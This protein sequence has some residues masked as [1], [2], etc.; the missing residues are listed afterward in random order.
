MFGNSL[1]NLA[2]SISYKTQSE[3][4]KSSKMSRDLSLLST[5][6][7]RETWLKT[8]VVERRTVHANVVWRERQMIATED[9]IYFARPDSDV[10]VDKL[11][12]QD[13]VS[14]GKVDNVDKGPGGRFSTDGLGIA[15]VLPVKSS[16][17]Q[18]KTSILPHKRASIISSFA[19]LESIQ[20]SMRETF[21][22]EIKGLFGKTTRSYFVRVGSFDE[23]EAWILA[24]ESLLKSSLRAQARRGNWLAMRQ[25]DVDEWYRSAPIRFGIAIAILIDFLAAALEAEYSPSRLGS[26]APASALV[27]L[28]ALLCALFALELTVCLIG[29]WRNRLGTPFISS[30]S[31]WALAAAVV[32]HL[33]GLLAPGLGLGPLRVVRVLRLFDVAAGFPGFRACQM[34]LNALRR[35]ELNSHMDIERCSAAGKV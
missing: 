25:R 3:E 6:P 15:A 1:K 26:A 11:S 18:F 2:K 17:E 23:R 22:F 9:N 4:V 10:V 32:F 19:S 13:I 29:G 8:G 34:V 33:C 28:D 12:I 5:L 20:D 16:F 7:A 27:H 30:T 35:G 31:N 24:I 21:A 14:V